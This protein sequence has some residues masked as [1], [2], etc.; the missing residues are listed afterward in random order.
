MYESA[1]PTVGKSLCWKHHAPRLLQNHPGKAP[2]IPVPDMR[3][4]I[5]LERRY[6]LLSTP[7]SSHNFRRGCDSQHR[8]AK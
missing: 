3:R 7:T 6:A 4:D 1:L 2:S 5:L 8:R